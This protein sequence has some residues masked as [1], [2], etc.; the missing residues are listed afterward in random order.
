MIV[1]LKEVVPGLFRGGAPTPL[2][3]LH[4]KKNLGINK[5]I[6]LDEAS[7]EKIDRTCKMLGINQVK[8]YLSGHKKSLLKLFNYDLK[9]LLLNN[10]PTFIHCHEGKD[11]T[12]LVIA[13][14]QCKYMGKSSKDALKEAKSFG[15]GIGVHP[16]MLHLYEKL[17]NS[18]N[19]ST[20]KNNADIVSNEREYIG[21]NRDSFLD[22]GHQGSFAPYLDKTRQY[23]M[24]SVYQSI[25]DQPQTRENYL[26]N[27]TL[28]KVHNFDE[29]EVVPQVGLFNNDAGNVGFGPVINP[30]GFIYD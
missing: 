3:V 24:D 19:K 13:L 25:N 15:F 9:K 14:F 5:I 21:D 12:G 11:R 6:S 2:D 30:G 1:K 23:P 8:L 17:I 7:G 10:G 27:E 28:N 22:E 4:L 29:K 18:C 26:S 20:D 16:Y